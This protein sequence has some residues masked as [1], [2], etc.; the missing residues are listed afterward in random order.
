MGNR[1]KNIEEE[2]TGLEQKLEKIVEKLQTKDLEIE[3]LSEEVKTA[4]STI[5]TLNQR[6]SDLE[7]SVNNAREITMNSDTPVSR[8]EKSLLLGDANLQ[9]ALHSDVENCSIRTIRGA[10]VDRMRCWVSEKMTWSPS[11]C[12]IY[13]GLCDLQII[14]DPVSILNQ[15]S[16]LVGELK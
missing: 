6:I 1:K 15:M 4:Y 5:T 16:A 2:V 14:S 3:L 11:R 13:A 7:K 12:F 10:N 9:R 8:E